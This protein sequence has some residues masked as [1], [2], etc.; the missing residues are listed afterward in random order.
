MGEDLPEVTLRLK[1][2]SASLS[3]KGCGT[4]RGGPNPHV[5][6]GS[7]PLSIGR[8]GRAYGQRM[9]DARLARQ[10]GQEQAGA[11]RGSPLSE[12]G[13]LESIRGALEAGAARKQ[14]LHRRMSAVTHSEPSLLSHEDWERLAQDCGG[15]ANMLTALENMLEETLRSYSGRFRTKQSAD[16]S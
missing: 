14:A 1:V 4:S 3:H 7:S 16:L 2:D 13:R 11:T 6:G 5:C 8:S 10:R 12:L 9:S 15:R